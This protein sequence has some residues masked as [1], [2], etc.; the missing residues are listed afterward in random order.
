VIV[1]PIEVLFSTYRAVDEVQLPAAM[2]YGPPAAA[3]WALM[4]L[5]R[6][7]GTWLGRV[8]SQPGFEAVEESALVP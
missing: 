2:S 1:H 8:G 6:A 5:V 3:A 7:M 4:L